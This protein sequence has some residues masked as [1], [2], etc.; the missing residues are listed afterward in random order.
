MPKKALPSSQWW[1]CPHTSFVVT[2][3]PFQFPT[4][5]GWVEGR[6]HQNQGN[7]TAVGWWVFVC[8]S[9]CPRECS[10]SEKLTAAE[11]SSLEKRTHDQG[12]LKVTIIFAQASVLFDGIKERKTD[13]YHDH[14]QRTLQR[15]TN[16]HNIKDTS[17]QFKFFKYFVFPSDL[18]LMANSTP[19]KII[20]L[21]KQKPLITLK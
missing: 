12:M 2:Q 14:C 8:G 19:E 21:A 11:D 13:L 1:S 15:E 16:P 17:L 6:Q 5:L 18:L 9:R 20:T 3:P 7:S 10:W 4:G